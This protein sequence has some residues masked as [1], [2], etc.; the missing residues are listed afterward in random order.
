MNPDVAA[1]VAN[2]QVISGLDHYL[3]SGRAE[4][5]SFSTSFNEASYLA[6]NPD[7]EAAVAAGEYSSGFEQYVLAGQFENRPL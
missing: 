7:V 3:R 5:R 4:G 1:A 2:H 6:H